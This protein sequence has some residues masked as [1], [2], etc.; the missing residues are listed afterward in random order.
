MVC[1]FTNKCTYDTLRSVGRGVGEGPG[2]RRLFDNLRRSQR[3]P[4]P[5]SRR[6]V[7]CGIPGGPSRSGAL[8]A[9]RVIFVP[10][11]PVERE[12]G[13]KVGPFARQAQT[14]VASR[15]PVRDFAGGEFRTAL[16][17]SAVHNHAGALPGEGR[18]S[19]R[20]APNVE[21]LCGSIFDILVV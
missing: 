3:I 5:A 15:Q 1:L 4:G 12:N 9:G 14:Q 19:R 13:T 10:L 20:L 2:G 11:P 8:Q 6:S 18:R 17:T 7:T 16:A 21:V